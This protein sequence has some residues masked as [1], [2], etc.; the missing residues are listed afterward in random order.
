MQGK[1]NGWLMRFAEII[2]P[3]NAGNIFGIIE[4]IMRCLEN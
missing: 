1:G 3:I 4:L 2:E